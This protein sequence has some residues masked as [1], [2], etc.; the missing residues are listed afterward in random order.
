MSE[1]AEQSSARNAI[2]LVIVAVVVAAYCMAYGVQT[3]VWFETHHWTSDNPWI[4][5]LPQALDSS[6]VPTGTTQLKAFDYEFNVPWPGK[7][8]ITPSPEHTEFR[9]DSGQVVVFF[10][11]QGQADM[12]HALTSGTSQ[13]E[14]NQFQNVFVGQSFS[15]NYDLY[16]AVYGS[17]PS[18]VSPWMAMRDAIRLNQLVLWKISFGLDA[19]PG[20]HLIAFGNNRG[21][22]F[23]D[24]STGRPVALRIF[25]GRDTQFRFIFLLA[26]SSSAKIAQA[27]IDSAVESLQAV[28]I[29]ER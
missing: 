13:T 16:K 27:D 17:A 18:E 28:P 12:L 20:I 1:Q 23:G 29:V 14:Y 5:D 8:K 7:A 15:S 3:L 22:E 24:P 26:A 9:F 4:D 19:A 10:D 21:F 11:P 2:I 6:N 25:N